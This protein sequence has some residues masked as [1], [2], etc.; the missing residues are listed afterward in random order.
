M[1]ARGSEASFARALSFAQDLIRIPGLSGEER[2]V[3]HRV[4]QEMEALKLDDVRIDDAGNVIGVARGRGEAPPVL[5]NCHLDV[6]AAGDASEW[7][8][9]PYG[10][11]VDGGYLH[12][13]GAM[14]IKGQ[15]AIQ[16]HAAAGL[17]G[18]SPGDV[19]V[20]HTVHEER[21]GLGMKSMLE[22]GAVAPQ[23]VV[24]GEATAGD[25]CIGHRG[26]SEV[27]IVIRG[28]AGHASAPERASNALDLVGDALAAVG[29]LA[30]LQPSDPVLGA[31]TVVATAVDV[32]PESR[33]VIP[34]H[35]VITLDWRILPGDTDRSLVRRVEEALQ[36]R[37]SELP[38]GLSW[39]VRI[40]TE[41]QTTWTG[42]TELRKQHTPGFLV[43]P[44][45][46][47]VTAAAHAVG[48]R[49]ALGPARVRPWRFA[50]DGGWSSD[51]HGILTMGFGPGKES[52]AHTN[53]ERLDLDEARWSFERYPE[54]VVAAQ[55]AMAS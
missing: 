50:T 51:V 22:S 55:R 18:S 10:G 20:A 25:V 2:A 39:E 7:E 37:K 11:V 38:E 49:A 3:A 43:A 53:R 15:L 28:V 32:L 35:V 19:I 45:H 21:G 5:L 46:P 44:D 30:D 27:E 17:A 29:A 8:Y 13:R 12:G 14:D 54:M 34:D 48:R 16:T 42:L 23:L 40:A 24:I 47:V 52:Y 41:E 36:H 1:H 33:N 26:R 31:S 4:K 9:P 6:V